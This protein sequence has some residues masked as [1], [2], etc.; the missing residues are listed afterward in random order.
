VDC[1]NA[2]GGAFRAAATRVV[3]GTPLET[4]AVVAPLKT[5]SGCAGVLALEL[6]DGR[7]RRPCVRACVEILA[8]QLALIVGYTPLVHAATA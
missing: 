2:V 8:A 6:R 3:E 7:E 4:G 1:D 5:A